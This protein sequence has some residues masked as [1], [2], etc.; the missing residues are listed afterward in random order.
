MLSY[1]WS[2]PF[3]QCTTLWRLAY[4]SIKRGQ[5]RQVKTN[6][7]RQRLNLHGAMNAKTLEVTVIE[8]ET[9]NGC[10]TIVP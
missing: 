10:A 2:M 6:S 4:G 7:A 5:K 8:S 9:V 3:T 1:C